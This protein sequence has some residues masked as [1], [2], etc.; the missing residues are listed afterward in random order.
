MEKKSLRR[1]K[2]SMNEVVEPEENEEEK[3]MCIITHISKTMTAILLLQKSLTYIITTNH[4]WSLA[5]TYVYQAVVHKLVTHQYAI[6]CAVYS[7]SVG[8]HVYYYAVKYAYMI[9]APSVA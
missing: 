7:M 2:H 5:C 8:F 3:G 6:F 1:P 4:L 9:A